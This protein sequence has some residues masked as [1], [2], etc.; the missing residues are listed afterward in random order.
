V[1]SSTS[2]TPWFFA[3]L[4]LGPAGQILYRTL[5]VLAIP[6]LI[7]WFVVLPRWRFSDQDE[8]LFR[9]AR[10]GDTAGV[11]RSLA[12]GARVN[13]AS[14]VDGKTAL[15][16]AA[17]FGHADTVRLLIDHGAD[18][19]L[20]GSDGQSALEMATAARAGER[21]PAIAHDLDTVVTALRAV[22]PGR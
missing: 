17:I 9:A 6:A 13:A 20:R 11:E 14:P 8:Q 19:S 5:F 12:A 16:R 4:G 7:V 21:D 15:F 18:A 2:R 3:L 22:E 10:H 1:N